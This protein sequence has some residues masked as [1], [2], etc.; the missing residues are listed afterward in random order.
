[1][2]GSSSVI[3]R[4][5]CQVQNG[6][7]RRYKAVRNAARMFQAL[8]RVPPPDM[9]AKTRYTANR[10]NRLAGVRALIV[11]GKRCSK[12]PWSQGG[13]EGRDERNKP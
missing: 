7:I 2:V 9:G 1:M 8:R 6:T 3:S 12:T 5:T 4:E 11:A 13:Q 10:M